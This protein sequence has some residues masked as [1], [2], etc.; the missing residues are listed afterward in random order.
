[1]KTTE[2]ALDTTGNLCYTIQ[3]IYTCKGETPMKKLKVG[4]IGAGNIATSAHLP[5]Y[6][7]VL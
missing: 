5:S 2:D 7:N 4:I 3:R 1:M 6:E